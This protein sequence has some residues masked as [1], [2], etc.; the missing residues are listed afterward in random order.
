MIR[1]VLR[2]SLATLTGL[3]L[4]VSCSTHARGSLEGMIHDSH[5]IF[6]RPADV[7]FAIHQA[8]A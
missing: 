1:F 2:F 6:A 7:D 3:L 4:A 5:E 8:M